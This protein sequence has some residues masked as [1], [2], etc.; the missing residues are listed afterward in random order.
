MTRFEVGGAYYATP[1]VPGA[2]R[3]VVVVTAVRRGVAYFAEPL[4]VGTMWMREI[5]GREVAQL[6]SEDG[7]EYTTSAAAT[8]DLGTAQELAHTLRPQTDKRIARRGRFFCGG[9]GI[10]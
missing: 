1:C 9:V 7:T 4:P 2:R 10:C 3:A 8:A 6:Q 5:N